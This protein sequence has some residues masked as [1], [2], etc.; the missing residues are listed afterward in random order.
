LSA[1]TENNNSDVTPMV[2]PEVKEEGKQQPPQVETP[3]AQITAV[4]AEGEELDYLEQQRKKYEDAYNK[5]IVEG[6]KT[7]SVTLS[8][9]K[10]TGNQ[11][12]DPLDDA[13]MI[14][15]FSGWE[16]KTYSRNRVSSQDFKIIE[17]LR[18]EWNR[19]RTP[20]LDANGDPQPDKL[21]PGKIADA[22]E[23][24]YRYVAYTYLGMPAKDFDRCD[25]EELRPALDSCTFKTNF[26]VPNSKS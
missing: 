2:L 4:A 5:R 15:E 22:M 1:T 26:F 7:E 12:P 13:K 11:I 20:P 17:K 3:K 19:L 6:V 21:D 8:L 18:G 16:N 24:M 9:R 14:D 10:P 25:W 23:K